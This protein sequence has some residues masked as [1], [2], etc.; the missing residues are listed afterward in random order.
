MPALDSSYAAARLTAFALA[1]VLVVLLAIMAWRAWQRSRVT[2][3]ER[4]RRRRMWLVS[5]GKMGDAVL[6]EIR[7]DLVFYNYVVRGVEYTASQDVSKIADRV[8]SD[9]S[10]M[11]SVSVKYDPKNPANSIVVAEEWSGLR[12]QRVG[13]EPRP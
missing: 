13:S 10:Q 4:E 1:I 6:A 7:D 3:D 11:P 5:T 9:L 2:P 12:G 8:P